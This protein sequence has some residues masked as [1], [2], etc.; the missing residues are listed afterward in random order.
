MISLQLRQEQ[1]TYIQLEE[2]TGLCL[3]IK[4]FYSYGCPSPINLITQVNRGSCSEYQIQKDDKYCAA[5]CLFVLYLTQII[6]FK[7]AVLTLF[8]QN[9]QK[10]NE[11]K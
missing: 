2:H 8:Y 4:F 10:I 6:G 11:E 1:L 9:I 5:Y 3:Q 7:N